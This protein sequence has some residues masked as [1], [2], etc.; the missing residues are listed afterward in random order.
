MVR[1]LLL[2]TKRSRAILTFR[3]HHAGRRPVLYI[4]LVILIGIWMPQSAAAKSKKKQQS[5]VLPPVAKSGPSFE[6]TRDW[7]VSTL[8][9]YGGYWED[10][11]GIW[12]VYSNVAISNSCV[13]TFQNDQYMN[14]YKSGSKPFPFDSGVVTIPLGA[15]TSSTLNQYEGGFFIS[16]LTG[17]ISAI[18]QTSGGG[19]T[20][21]MANYT[22]DINRAVRPVA[23]Q[24]T[25][26]NPQDMAKRFLPAFQHMVDICKGTYQAPVQQKQPF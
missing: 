25:P 20:P 3:P 18:T 23:G 10:S 24:P 2:L 7:I 19:L 4:V 22:L 9:Q 11:G 16:I 12:H 8:T 17:S 6:A 26:D 14:S 21:A 13:L 1:K 15:V 5:E